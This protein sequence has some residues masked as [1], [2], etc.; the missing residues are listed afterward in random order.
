MKLF[1]RLALILAGSAA[2]PAGLP[3]QTAGGLAAAPLV[4]AAFSTNGLGPEGIFSGSNVNDAALSTNGLGPKIQFNT[5]DYIAGTNFP[6][7]PFLYTFVATNTGDDTLEISRVQSSCS[8]TVIGEGSARNAWTLQK[9]APGQVCRIPVE[10]STANFRGQLIKTVTVTSN[11]RMRSNVILQISG[12]VWLPIEVAPEM[13]VFN[14]KSD[15]T[16]LSTQVL[17]IFNRMA[18]PLTLSDPQ[19][20]TNAFS[21]VLKTNVPGQEFELA[22][23]AAPPPGLPPALSVAV[24][25]GVIS[26]KSSATNKNPLTISVFE[27]I[28]PEI[29]VFPPTLQLP[30]GPLVQPSTSLVTI[31]DNVADLVVSDPAVNAPGVG[32]AITMM[33]TNRTYVLSVIFPLGFEIRAGQNVA[34][35]VKT[36]NPRFPA[37]SVPITPM[38]GVPPPVPPAA[39]VPRLY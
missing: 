1:L 15:A 7:D 26:L 32:V 33:Q 12:V 39:A 38:P 30:V 21:A 29:T 8:C 28:S 5:E 35:T 20:S 34:L 3:A 13:A 23:S 11:D 31:R 17:R 25:Q 37:I 6:G 27:T 18:T 36:D 4:P 14:F 10:V 16:N 22:V 19:C 2:F 24:I 9:V